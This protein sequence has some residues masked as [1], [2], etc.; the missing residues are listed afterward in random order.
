MI[1]KPSTLDFWSGFQAGRGLEMGDLVELIPPRFNQLT[2][3]PFVGAS[4]FGGTGVTPEPAG[5]RWVRGRAT[6]MGHAP[7]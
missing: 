4:V 3:G 2:V 6:G 5:R 7:S 1:L